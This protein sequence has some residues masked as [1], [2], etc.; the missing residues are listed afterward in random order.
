MCRELLLKGEYLRRLRFFAEDFSR[1]NVTSI[2]TLCR[3][4]Y[5]ICGG[6][7]YISVFHIA[8]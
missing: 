5:N 7:L 1:Y 3:H 4:K 8:E 2:L 6:P